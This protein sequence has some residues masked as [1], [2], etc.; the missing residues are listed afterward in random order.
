MIA[1]WFHNLQLRFSTERTHGS[2]LD[3]AGRYC[4][5]S[6]LLISSM[7]A[8][9]VG[10]LMSAARVHPP[11]HGTV[12]ARS[13]VVFSVRF[14]RPAALPVIKAYGT[15]RVEWV[16]TTDAGFVANLKHE[17][18]WFGGTLNAN[19]PLP[20]DAGY[21]R[22]FDGKV[23][24]APW[25][26][27]WGKYWVTTTHSD[28]QMVMDKQ[29]RAYLAMGA[30][31]IQHDDPQLQAYAAV[32]QAGDFNE[33]TVKGF[34][35]WLAHK[36]DPA[37]VLSAGLSGFSGDYRE[38]LRKRHNVADA[39]DYRKRFRTFPSTP[40][41]L[42]YVR[43]TVLDHH[44]RL[45]ALMVQVRGKPVPLSMNLGGLYE[46][47]ESNSFFFLA[48]V[49]DY[50]M[51]ETQ[52]MDPTLQV[53]QANTARALGVGFVPSLKPQSL[54]ENRVAIALFYALGGQ[55][56]VPWDV[57]DGNDEQGKPKRFF[58]APEDYAD[59]YA[60]VRANPSLF[61]EMET[62]PVVGV[63]VPV[64]K[65]DTKL[66]RGLSQRLVE[67]QVP[68]AF[69]PVGGTAGY[70]ADP[71]R[72][73]YLRLLIKTNADTD[74]RAE[75]LKALADSGVPRVAQAA[76]TDRQIASLRPFQVAQGAER[77]RLLPRANPGD[78]KRLTV[79]LVDSSRGEEKT[80]SNSECTR[81]IGIR[82]DYLGGAA[83]A[84]AR[85]VHQAG[86]TDLVIEPAGERV[87]LNLN[88]CLLWG[89]A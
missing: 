14:T 6:A 42:D 31:S 26:Q 21:A 13:D 60:F 49:A 24:A 48:Q 41:W 89:F 53:S 63:V 70:R 39:Q 58:G 20:D 77:V 71:A 2:R 50:S 78:P 51:A 9:A 18:P 59:L 72:L 12:P 76:M 16:Y 4:L 36:A 38:W 30:D 88:G 29:L 47:I 87:Y 8:G 55:P 69:V 61:D 68:F 57:Y 64:D 37:R 7:M 17:A 81:R 83:V 82:R 85:W 54:A 80:S 75:D 11:F 40:L 35:N 65:G 79:H 44:R 46:P 56:V 62:T 28:T 1:Q 86:A 3:Q 22:D 84:S 43:S 45:R 32:H 52:I 10:D 25:M 67:Q 5:G 73:R 19:G 27:G 66:V 34:P 33:A 23:L 15:T 74:Y